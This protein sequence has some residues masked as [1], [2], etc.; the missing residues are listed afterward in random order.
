MPNL[1]IIPPSVPEG[2]CNTLGPNWIQQIINLMAQAVAVFTDVGTI[3]LNQETQPNANQRDFLWFRPSTGITYRWDTGTSA[4]ISPNQ[5]IAGGIDRRWVE[6]DATAIQ[7]YDGGDT[8]PSGTNSGPMWEID[9]NYDGRSPMGP[10]AILGA[11]PPKTLLLSEDYGEGA[12]AGT[13]AQLV[14]HTHAFGVSGGV[15]T[16]NILDGDNIHT[17]LPGGGSVAGL[18][19]G[20]TGD[21]Q[22][23]LTIEPNQG[24]GDVEPSP[25]VHP[26]RGI[27]AIKRTSR[28]NYVAS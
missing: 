20:L 13:A 10:G 25:I 5:A 22:P 8:N 7:T 6:G 17:V 21:A 19:I 1:P 28:I 14:S 23:S 27:Y 15:D 16:D 26:V 2:F 11:F 18:Q 24:S 9:H 12:H 3:I 4:W